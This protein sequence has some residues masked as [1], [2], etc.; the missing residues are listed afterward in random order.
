MTG[1]TYHIL[2]LEHNPT[3]AEMI[4]AQ[5]RKVGLPASTKRV[6]TKELFLRAIEE[7][8]PDIIVADYAVPRFDILAA[9]KQASVD[10]PGLPWVIVSAAGSEDAAVSCLKAGASD[11]LSK[12][13]LSR[14]APAVKT[15]LEKR[16]ASEARGAESQKQPE[17]PPPVAA[18]AGPAP[19]AAGVPASVPGSDPVLS[20]LFSA[21]IT[22]TPDLIAFVDVDGKRLYNN[23]AYSGVLED[24]DILQG[25]DSFLDIHPDDRELVKRVFLDSLRTGGGK[26]IEYRLLDLH[27][28]TRTI[29]SQGSILRE[30]DGKIRCLGII[31]RDVTERKRADIALQGLVAGTASTTGTEFYTALVRHLA[32]ALNVKYALVSE[33][34][35]GKRDRVRA[36]A[37]WAAGQWV[38]SFEYDVKGMTCEKVIMDGK[39]TYYPDHVQTLFPGER[40][41]AAMHA[42]CYLGIPFHDT[43]G[44]ITGHLFIMDDRPLADYERTRSL[45]GIF[46]ARVAM[47]L[48]RKRTIDRLQR[49]E[50]SLRSILDSLN[51]GVIMTDMDDSIT[52]VN[53]RMASL[54]GYAA[55]DMSGRLASS[56]LLP[57]D[58]WEMLQ[59]R[60]RERAQGIAE[61][62]TTKLRRKDGSF[63]P[64]A[65]SAAPYRDQ[66]GEVVGTLAVVIELGPAS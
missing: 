30:P 61:R 63:V 50:A 66:H 62:Y 24:P 26:R 43:A 37:Y 40:S 12:K 17:A 1:K 16:T 6:G 31:S 42:I 44:E 4:E 20:S 11:Y 55:S 51:D 49:S 47:E 38:P 59:E 33:L 9:L 52:Y 48:E 60:N 19:A 21:L 46:G 57:Q 27:G 22:A 10:L 7:F 5:L 41:L 36:L 64:V 25:T 53:P 8:D 45:M 29:E 28:N 2:I 54:L 34:V 35:A 3:D 13:N 23:P 15:L 14:L 58:E 32:N 39:M 56:L 65:L 18:A